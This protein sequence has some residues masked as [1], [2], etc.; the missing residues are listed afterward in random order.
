MFDRTELRRHPTT[1]CSEVHLQPFYGIYPYEF[2]QGV[3]PVGPPPCLVKELLKN[4]TGLSM[5]AYLYELDADVSQDMESL[6]V[7]PEINRIR[8][9][10]RPQTLY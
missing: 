2:D 5:L 7:V 3:H 6:L 1:T 10:I 4:E 9:E 8:L